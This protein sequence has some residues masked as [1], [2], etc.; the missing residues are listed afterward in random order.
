MPTLL[1]CVAHYIVCFAPS[2]VA[3]IPLLKFSPSFSRLAY[4]VYTPKFFHVISSLYFTQLHANSSIFQLEFTKLSTRRP[5]ALSESLP[6]T[7]ILIW[8]SMNSWNTTRGEQQLLFRYSTEG[9]KKERESI[10]L[11]IYLW[12]SFVQSLGNRAHFFC[13]GFFS[14]HSLFWVEE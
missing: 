4:I 1:P 6:I 12:K 8:K 7:E 13:S 5:G 10:I 9:K 2:G 11:V 3:R 14:F